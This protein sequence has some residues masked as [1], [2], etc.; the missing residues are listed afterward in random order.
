MPRIHLTIKEMKVCWEF[1]LRSAENQQEIEF[2]QADTQPRSVKEIARDNFIGKL[3]EA[4]FQKF[5][6]DNYSI[7]IE[8]DFNYY[9]RR[10]WDDQDALINGWTIDVKGTRTGSRWFLIELSKLEFRRNEGRLPDFFVSAVV[11]WDRKADKALGYV[12]IIGYTHIDEIKLGASGTIFIKKGDPIPGTQTKMQADNFGRRF[13]DLNSD[14]D[15]FVGI[16]RKEK[17]KN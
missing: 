8:L 11:G 10:Q 16:L 9:P 7:K 1:S 3:A 2:G 15:K 14:W 12:D 6:S 4:A 13:T 17:E 5:L